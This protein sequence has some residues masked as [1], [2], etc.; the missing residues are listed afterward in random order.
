MDVWI[1]EIDSGVYGVT[2]DGETIF[3]KPGSFLDAVKMHN[4]IE[5]FIAAM[6]KNIHSSPDHDIILLTEE[7]TD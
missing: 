5:E 3:G 6:E 2:T 4:C 1:K 7:V